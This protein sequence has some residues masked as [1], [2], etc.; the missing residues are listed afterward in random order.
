MIVPLY[1]TLVKMDIQYSILISVFDLPLQERYQGP[2]V[3]PKKGNNPK[4]FGAE[5]LRGAEEWTGIVCTGK[6]SGDILYNN[7]NYYVML[8]IFFYYYHY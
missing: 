5:V 2:E 4:G 6:G 1:S 8:Y 7:N 3:Q